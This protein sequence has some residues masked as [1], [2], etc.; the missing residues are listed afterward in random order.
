M[1]IVKT[2]PISEIKIKQK[3][4]TLQ[5]TKQLIYQKVSYVILVIKISQPVFHK[6]FFG[7]LQQKLLV[8]YTC[9]ILA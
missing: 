6:M 8:N 4:C 9:K 7:I 5:D 3:D 1:D 2:L